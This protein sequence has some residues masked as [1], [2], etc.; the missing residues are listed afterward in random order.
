MNTFFENDKIEFVKL[1]RSHFSYLI[2]WLNSEHVKEWF[3]NSTSKQIT[4]HGIEKKL[5]PRIDKTENIDCFI[6]FIKNE[7]IGYIQLYN[8]REFKREGYELSLIENE[9]KEIPKLAAIDFYIGNTEFL[10]KGYGTEILKQF[11]I[12]FVDNNFNAC[13][14]DPNI[15]NIRSINC[16]KKS[17]FVYIK[18]ILL[19]KNSSNSI[20]IWRNPQE[21]CK[22][23]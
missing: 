19:S 13:M 22:A 16:Y 23:K 4:L 2:K 14:V 12:K 8:A 9:I 20:L 7:P 18:D 21:T 11:L 15:N 10:N 1:R 3:G 5:G 17:G 6:I